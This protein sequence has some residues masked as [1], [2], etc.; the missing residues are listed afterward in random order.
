MINDLI[1]KYN[2][3]VFPRI[4]HFDVAARRNDVVFL[5]IRFVQLSLQ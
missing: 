1:C 4:T 2:V 5:I 3:C